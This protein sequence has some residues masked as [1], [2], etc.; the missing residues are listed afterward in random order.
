MSSYPDHQEHINRGRATR[1]TPEQR[2]AELLTLAIESFSD[3]GLGTSTHTDVA[4]LAGLAIPTIFHYYPTRERL[5]EAVLGEVVRFIREELLERNFDRSAPAADV[6]ET[7]LM[8]FVQA[9]T[10][11]ESHMR[12]WFEWGST[13]RD[14]LRTSYCN[15]YRQ[16]FEHFVRVLNHGKRSGSLHLCL[17]SEHTAQIIVG[18]SHMLIRMKFAGNPAAAIRHAVDSLVR[19]YLS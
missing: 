8:A 10:T 19:I 11:H 9:S 1:L 4:Q 7:T 17:S 18:L 12:I 3:K 16:E 14:D 15:L 13:L 6:I 2:K 5:L